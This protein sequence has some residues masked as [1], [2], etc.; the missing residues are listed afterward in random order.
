VAEV[1]VQPTA[2]ITPGTC[3]ADRTHD[4]LQQ[5]DI[6]TKEQRRLGEIT[7]FLPTARREIVTEELFD[8]Y[9][10][11]DVLDQPD[12]NLLKQAYRCATRAIPMPV[13]DPDTGVPQLD[14][15]GQPLTVESNEWAGLPEV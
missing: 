6:C 5:R 3:L 14:E 2:F 4:V 8:A 12:S 15:Q 9:F 1:Q 13:T 10:S 11:L 7:P